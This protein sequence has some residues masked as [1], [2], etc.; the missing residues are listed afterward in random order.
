MSKIYPYT[1]KILTEKLSNE[2]KDLL[3]WEKTV[4]NN[5]SESL[6]RQALGNIPNNK[7]RIDELK[8]VI[9]LINSI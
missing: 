6:V 9:E 1:I 4:K 5:E 8:K 2:E 3:F 7:Y